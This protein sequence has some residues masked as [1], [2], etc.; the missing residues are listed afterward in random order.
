MSETPLYKNKEVVFAT[1]STTAGNHI[2]NHKRNF[3]KNY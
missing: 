1:I 3:D 2:C